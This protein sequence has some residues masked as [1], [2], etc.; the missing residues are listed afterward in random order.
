V[1]RYFTAIQEGDTEALTELLTPE[2][3]TSWPQ[4]GER[5]TGAQACIRVYQNYPGGPPRVQLKRIVG[6]GTS[7]SPSSSPITG[8][9]AGT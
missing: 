9:S 8:P 2:A 3:V 4:T 6:G 1:E 5:I 7:G